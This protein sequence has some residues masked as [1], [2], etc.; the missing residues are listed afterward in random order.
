MADEY[1]IGTELQCV[2]VLCGGVL[3]FS[4]YATSYET[5]SV[6]IISISNDFIFS[7]MWKFPGQRPTL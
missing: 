5:F 3:S 6:I 4:H 7:G 1:Y 2:A